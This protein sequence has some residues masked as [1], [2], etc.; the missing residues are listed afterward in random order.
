MPILRPSH[1]QSTPAYFLISTVIYGHIL[2][3]ANINN[4]ALVSVDI[5]K[6][7]ME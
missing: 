7:H 6:H 4:A 2:Y 1:A 3:I 5:N